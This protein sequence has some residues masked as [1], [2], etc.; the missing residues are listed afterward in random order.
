M[1]DYVG[2]PSAYEDSTPSGYVSPRTALPSSATPAC[3]STPSPWLARLWDD[4]AAKNREAVWESLPDSI[5]D[6]AELHPIGAHDVRFLSA[7]V[8]DPSAHAGMAAAALRTLGRV[9]EDEPKWLGCAIGAM[10]VGLYQPS[11]LTRF[12][13]A[14]AIWQAG[15][16]ALRPSLLQR[17]VVE[18]DPKVRATL[19]HV[20]R[21][22]AR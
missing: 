4:A 19:Q 15:A 12:A 8:T 6:A 5:G 20:L 16:R 1:M 7:W 14:E 18:P 10:H 9:C 13:A 21:I 3:A 22:W 2:S 11:A 17:S